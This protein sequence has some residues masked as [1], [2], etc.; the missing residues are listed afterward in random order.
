MLEKLGV[1][2][3]GEAVK[4]AASWVKQKQKTGQLMCLL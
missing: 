3:L 2:V 4:K 1:E